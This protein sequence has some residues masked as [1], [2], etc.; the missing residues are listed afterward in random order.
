MTKNAETETL[1]CLMCP[2]KTPN[3][4]SMSKHVNNAHMK[5]LEWACD[6]CDFRTNMRCNL[7]QHVQSKHKS[8]DVKMT[9]DV[10]RFVTTNRAYLQKHIK[11]V[12][13]DERTDL[14]MSPVRHRPEE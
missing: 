13:E 7:L 2:Y 4:Q 10:C 8:G 3:K 5:L 1:S 9:C 12:H 14:Q 11:K 6:D